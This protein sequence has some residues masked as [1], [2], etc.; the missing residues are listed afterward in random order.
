VVRDIAVNGDL[1]DH[2]LGMAAVGQ[3]LTQLRAS[4]RGVR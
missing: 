4:L 2:T 1:L 3:P